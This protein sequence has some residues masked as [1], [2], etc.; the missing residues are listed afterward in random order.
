MVTIGKPPDHALAGDAIHT[1]LGTRLTLNLMCPVLLVSMNCSVSVKVVVS[2]HGMS[3][4]L[5]KQ[6]FKLA[7]PPPPPPPPPSQVTGGTV[8]MQAAKER[9]AGP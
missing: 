6:Q 9:I 2:T 3:L 5:L 8:V 1:G 4:L 7:P